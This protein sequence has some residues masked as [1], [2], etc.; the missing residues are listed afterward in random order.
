M[1]TLK[2]VSD[3]KTTVSFKN[4]SCEKHFNSNQLVVFLFLLAFI[5]KLSG[6]YQNAFFVAGGAIAIGTC[7]L[8]FIPS[9]MPETRV[10]KVETDKEILE[11]GETAQEFTDTSDSVERSKKS[12]SYDTSNFALRRSEKG[13]GTQCILDMLERET[14][15]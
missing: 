6:S 3:A 2:T 10:K 14:D 15:V 13:C 12:I 9:F 8:S 5:F 11:K 4:L 7:T 1:K